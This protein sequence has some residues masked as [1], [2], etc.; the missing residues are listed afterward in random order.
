MKTEMLLNRKCVNVLNDLLEAHSLP[1][2]ITTGVCRKEL[3][4]VVLEYDERDALLVEWLLERI[5][6]DV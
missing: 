1:I 5:T 3:L 4:T 2:K 6:E